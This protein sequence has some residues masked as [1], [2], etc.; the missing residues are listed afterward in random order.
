MFCAVLVG[1]AHEGTSPPIKQNNDYSFSIQGYNT[2]CDVVNLGPVSTDFNY[3]ETVQVT[4]QTIS[5]LEVERAIVS[6]NGVS[7]NAAGSVAMLL[8]NKS[9][10]DKTSLISLNRN[11]YCNPSCFG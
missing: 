10:T 2:T 4:G 6:R 9:I 8:Y 7:F 1:S 5:C 11:T 3:Y